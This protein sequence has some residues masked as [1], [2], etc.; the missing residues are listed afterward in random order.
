MNKP[1]IYDEKTSILYSPSGDLLKRVYCPKAKRWNQLINDDQSNKTRF[2]DSCSG[3]VINLDSIPPTESLALLISNPE[4]CVYTSNNSRNVVFLRSNG[5]FAPGPYDDED[6][7]KKLNS[8]NL[9][10]IRISTDITE[11]NKSVDLKYWPHVAHSASIS[12]KREIKRHFQDHNTGYVFLDSDTG[13]LMD[14]ELTRIFSTENV[15]E[16]YLQ[17]SIAAY[18]IPPEAVDGTRF[19]IKRPIAGNGFHGY[20]DE[21]CAEGVLENKKIVIDESTIYCQY[22]HI[23]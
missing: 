12:L 14:E 23:G 2:C 5:C 10:E 19:F 1:Y 9:C 17:F 21:W 20:V 11:I 6:F 16:A 22:I 4:T 3:R 18:L 13:N 8:K 7:Y 15:S